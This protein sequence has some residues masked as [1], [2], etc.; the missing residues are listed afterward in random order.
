MIALMIDSI[1]IWDAATGD[2]R[3]SLQRPGSLA[4]QLAISPDGRWMA[5]T[6]RVGV[7]VAIQDLS[8]TEP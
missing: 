6:Q 3:D 5:T 1:A 8:P 2:Q 4:D 7:G